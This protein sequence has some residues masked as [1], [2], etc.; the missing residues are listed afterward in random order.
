MRKPGISEHRQHGTHQFAMLR[1]QGQTSSIGVPDLA[2]R[3]AKAICSSVNRDFFVAVSSWIERPDSTVNPLVSRGS[4]LRWQVS[5]RRGELRG[6]IDAATWLALR[7]HFAEN[8]TYPNRLPWIRYSAIPSSIPS[9]RCLVSPGEAIAPCGAADSAS[10]T[11]QPPSISIS[12]VDACH[13]PA[14]R[15]A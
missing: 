2:C 9:S 4:V 13:W 10:A 3:G 5:S 1:S 8:R 7:N 14:K 6:S 12:R 15:P 11:G